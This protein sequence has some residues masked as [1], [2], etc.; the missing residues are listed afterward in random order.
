MIV[1]SALKI[2]LS[3]LSKQINTTQWIA[4]QR[5]LAEFRSRLYL[6]GAGELNSIRSL[7]AVAVTL[8]DLTKV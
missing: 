6:R 5:R 1:T 7:Y 3:F 8:H 4:N 2:R